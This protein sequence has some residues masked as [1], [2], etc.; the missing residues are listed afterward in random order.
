M[1]SNGNESGERYGEVVDRLE[2]V[3][4][5]LET[6]QLSLEQSLQEFET[7][8]KL[9]RRGEQLLGEAERRVEELLEHQGGDRAVPLESPGGKPA[10]DDEDVPF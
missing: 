7:G 9:V 1:P 8:I 2:E 6:G 5:K 4:R 10:A 3:V